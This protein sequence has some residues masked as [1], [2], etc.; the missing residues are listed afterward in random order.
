MRIAMLELLVTRESQHTP[1]WAAVAGCERCYDF[2]PVC[3]SRKSGGPTLEFARWFG[4]KIEARLRPEDRELRDYWRAAAMNGVDAG[5]VAAESPRAILPGYFFDRKAGLAYPSAFKA[6]QYY[7][8]VNGRLFADLTTH[9]DSRAGLKNLER[10]VLIIQAHQDPIGDKTAEDI[11]ALITG[12]KLVYIDAYSKL[13]ASL[14]RCTAL[15][16]AADVAIAG[17]GAAQRHA[18]GDSSS[19]QLTPAIAD[20]QNLSC[21]QIFSPTFRL[22]LPNVSLPL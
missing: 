5:K 19:P 12:S 4:D 21:W 13:R 20:H 15:Y 17:S 22:G 18:P 1:G 6:D 7:P 16:S 14:G 11:R 8:D 10:P 3:E 2:R 9:Y